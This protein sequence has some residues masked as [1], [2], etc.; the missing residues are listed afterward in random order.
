MPKTTAAAEP[1]HLGNDLQSS[2]EP[3]TVRLR[4]SSTSRPPPS[5]P[6]TSMCSATGKGGYHRRCSHAL[7]MDCLRC[8]ATLQ[9]I[10]SGPEAKSLASTSAAATAVLRST[11]EPDPTEDT[12][13]V[14][15]PLGTT[16]TTRS[17]T[18][19]SPTDGTEGKLVAGGVAGAAVGAALPPLA[20]GVS[21]GGAPGSTEVERRGASGARVPPL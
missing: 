14:A 17:T 19:A 15:Q 3:N 1:T 21:A 8:S 2:G 18:S 7:S 13:G 5:T 6:L 16:V 4:C 12:N 10:S 20:S 9:P 11:M